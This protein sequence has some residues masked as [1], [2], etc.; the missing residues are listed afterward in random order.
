M[1]L[2]PR[3]I[4]VARDEGIYGGKYAESGRDEEERN[5]QAHI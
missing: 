5:Q 3:M 2:S 4:R 1:N